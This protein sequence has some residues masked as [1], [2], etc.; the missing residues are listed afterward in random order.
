MNRIDHTALKPTTT[1]LDIERLCQECVEYGF[2][3]VCVPPCYVLNCDPKVNVSTVIGFPLGN[4]YKSIKVK[5]AAN[6]VYD[7]ANELDV[8]WNL[9][10]FLNKEYLH[11]LE[12]LASIVKEVAPVHVKVIVEE[13]YI[14]EDLL[15]VAYFIVRDSGAWAIKTCTGYAGSARE[16]TI[17]LWKSLG[18]LKIKAAGGI[19]TLSDYNKMIGAGADIIG[20]SSGVGIAE[21]HHFLSTEDFWVND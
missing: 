3:G 6:A 20:T 5:E 13:A 14:P 19:R 9:G 4:N 18:D 1:R 17:R 16:S 15:T 2:R 7:G 11:V 10:R 21:E 12:E 8:V